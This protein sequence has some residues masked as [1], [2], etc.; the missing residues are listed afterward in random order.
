[1]PPCT[2]SC[3]SGLEGRALLRLG[4]AVPGDD[5]R[6]L[7]CRLRQVEPGRDGDPVRGRVAHQVGL[8]ERGRVDPAHLGPGPAHQAPSCPGVTCQ[9]SPGE[10]RRREPQEE[11][12]RAC[13]AGKRRPAGHALGELARRELPAARLEE[14]EPAGPV[15]IHGQCDTATPSRATASP[16]TSQRRLRVSGRGAAEASARSRR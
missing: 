12:R 10:T 3:A 1:M 11:R 4:S 9:T 15:G 6:A 8:D 14:V 2:S 7:P 16:S 13:A 5:H